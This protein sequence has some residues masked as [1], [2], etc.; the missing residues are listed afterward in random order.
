[1]QRCTCSMSMPSQMKDF[2]FSLAA[3]GKQLHLLDI[4]LFCNQLHP[5]WT[6]DFRCQS[7]ST[8]VHIHH[9]WSSV[10]STA[11]YCLSYSRLRSYWIMI[12][13]Y[14]GRAKK[15]SKHGSCKIHQNRH[16]HFGVHALWIFSNCVGPK[17]CASIGIH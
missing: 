17:G 5:C 14:R 2:G 12:C 4:S 11:A 3:S 15:F 16:N 1:M 9:N 10:R 7:E 13:V 6:F 8:F